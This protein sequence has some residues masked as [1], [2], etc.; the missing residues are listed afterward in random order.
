MG[1]TELGVLV[2]LTPRQA[3][4]AFFDELELR[5]QAGGLKVSRMAHKGTITQGDLTVGV[6]EEWVPS[7]RVSI[8]WH[9]KDWDARATS[10]I[11]VTFSPRAGGTKITIENG[12][13][14]KVVGDDAH[15]LLGWFTEEVAAPVLTASAP[16][17]LGDWIT[18]RLA[19]RPSGKNSRLTYSNPVYHWPN[20]F[21]ILD[22]LNLTPDDTMVEIGCGGGAFL[23]E[24]LKSG[25]RASAID[26][27]ADM[28]RLATETNRLA[29]SKRRLKVEVGD[30][31]Q[32]PYPSGVFTCAVMTGVLPFITDPAKAFG[33]V[34]RVLQRGGRFVAFTASKEMRGTPAAPEPM[35]SRIRF[36]EDAEL[37]SLGREAGFAEA[38]VRHPA[39]FDYAKKAGVPKAGLE[40]FR[41][42]SGSLL[43]VCRK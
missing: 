8:R 14:G 42:T 27:S 29:V 21:A 3:F 28:V 38:K 10:V 16:D 2:S 5:L 12:N 15:E 43:L 39:L 13:W 37:E 17:R 1:N 36:Y 4:D 25:C 33:E 41:G 9:P 19:R 24:A 35:A 7:K 6:I 11:G 22:V 30:A 34:C 40:L 20:F 31:G 26:H 23:H 18:D 32:L